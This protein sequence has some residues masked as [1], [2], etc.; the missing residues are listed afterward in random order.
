MIE[1][2]TYLLHQVHDFKLVTDVIS[3]LTSTALMWRRHVRAA[4]VVGFAPSAVASALVSRRD[5]SPLRETRRGRYVLAH[6][7]AAAQVVRLLGQVI[8]WHAA[9]RRRPAGTALGAITIL[10]G[11]SYGLARTS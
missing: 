8:M 9:Y 7:P 10:A 5:L 2:D 4:V 11:W 6:M 3:G 1:R